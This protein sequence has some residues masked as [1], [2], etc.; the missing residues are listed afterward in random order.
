L[1]GRYLI[2]RTG[3]EELRAFIPHSPARLVDYSLVTKTPIDARTSLCS[4]G[5]TTE[6]Y[7]KRAFK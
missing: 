5:G 3:D 2:F 7:M 1:T 4:A 6:R